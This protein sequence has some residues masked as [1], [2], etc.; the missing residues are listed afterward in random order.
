MTDM[1]LHARSFLY[2]FPSLS[3]NSHFRKIPKHSHKQLTPARSLPLL[4]NPKLK[5]FPQTIVHLSTD[6]HCRK[7]RIKSYM[8]KKRVSTLSLC[9]SPSVKETSYY[10]ENHECQHSHEHNYTPA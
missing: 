10:R 8:E 6:G 4:R 7:Q 9:L 2:I 1:N 3:K 5:T